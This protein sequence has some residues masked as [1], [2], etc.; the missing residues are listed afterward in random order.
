LRIRARRPDSWRT[1]RAETAA[2]ASAFLS[3]ANDANDL[4][5]SLRVPK[6]D[7]PKVSVPSDVRL[8]REIGQLTKRP[9]VGT[10]RLLFDRHLRRGRQA[11][12]GGRKF[13]GTN[14]EVTLET[15]SVL[16]AMQKLPAW[17]APCTNSFHYSGDLCEVV[18]PMVRRKKLTRKPYG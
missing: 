12:S 15:T 5:I 1:P 9:S 4:P 6:I 2:H 11:A 8:K 13:Q 10:I 7:P 17:H 16:L 18:H 14:E 3:D